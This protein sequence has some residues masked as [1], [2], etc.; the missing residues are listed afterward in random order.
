MEVRITRD[1]EEIFNFLSADP[2]LNLYLI[3]DMDDF[4]WPFTIWYALYEKAI[5]RSIALFYKGTDPPALLLFYKGDPHFAVNLLRSIKPSLPEKFN[6][7]LSPGLIELF[8]SENIIK[9]YGQN[10]R[11]I[12]K[13]EPKLVNDDNIRK[14]TVSDLPAIEEFY[15]ISYPENWFTEKMVET[16]KYFGYYSGEKLVGVSGVHVWSAK[17][18][19]AA[20]GNIS[21]HPEYRGRGIAFKLT[22]FLCSDLRKDAR[23]IGL[24]VRSDNKA[25]I[26]CYENAGFE[27]NCLY[28]ECFVRNV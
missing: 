16:G 4:F 11:M 18:S 24:N 23:T 27:I 10:F 22:S 7:H 1:K 5:L 20:L 3:G 28:D 13:K 9:N 14:L 25:A 6:V 19:I 15:R 12:L 8:G 26:K 2:E 21:T 17:Y